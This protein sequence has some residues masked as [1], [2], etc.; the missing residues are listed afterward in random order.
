MRLKGA[1]LILIEEFALLIK[2]VIKGI[3]IELYDLVILLIL[4]KKVNWL[5]PKSNIKTY[6]LIETDPRRRSFRWEDQTI[7]EIFP[8]LTNEFLNNIWTCC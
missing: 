2:P 4:I 8:Q 7:K 1:I 3:I 6:I 5:L